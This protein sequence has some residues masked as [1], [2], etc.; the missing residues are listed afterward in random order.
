MKKE[1]SQVYNQ[2]I[3]ALFWVTKKPLRKAV[4]SFG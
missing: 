4:I 3:F 1:K 2:G